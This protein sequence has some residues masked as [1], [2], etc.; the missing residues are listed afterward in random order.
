MMGPTQQVAIKSDATELDVKP[1]PAADQPKSFAGAVGEYTLNT[2]VKPTTVS[3]GDP[4]TLTAKIEG[5]GNF[6]RVTAPQL[7]DPR[8]WRA[9]PPSAKFTADDDI[10]VSGAKT[11]EMALI[12]AAGQDRFPADGVEL[13]RPG[14]GT[15]FHPHRPARADQDRGPMRRRADRPRPWRTDRCRATAA[16]AA[17]DI[18]YIRA[19]SE[20][21]GRNL[22]AAL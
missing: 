19:D 7:A 12:P 1:L 11:F 16:P 14:E 13:F 4:I 15:L 8:G 10:G 17:P 2:S 22:R 21:V 6:D 5:R 20:R 9:Y 3:A 18:L